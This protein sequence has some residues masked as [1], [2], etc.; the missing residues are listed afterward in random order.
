MNIGITTRRI[1]QVVVA[2]AA[3]T[4]LTGSAQAATSKPDRLSTD[5]YR[6]LVLRSDALNQ[7]YRLGEWK[8]M[9]RGMTAPEYRALMIRSEALNKQYGLGRWSTSTASSSQTP[10]GVSG[11]AWGAFGIGAAAML[12]LVLLTAGVIAA[13]RFTRDT[14]RMRTS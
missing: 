11:F 6:A 10:S 13:S 8:A 3:L 12:G 5:Q 4:A 14:P 9:P 7:R 1:A 2:V